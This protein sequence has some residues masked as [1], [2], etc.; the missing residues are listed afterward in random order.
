MSKAIS[1]TDLLAKKYDLIK[2]EGE[3]YDNFEEPEASGTWFISGQSGMGKTSFMLEL[4]KQLAKFDRVL[5][6]SLEEGTSLTMQKAWKRH[7]VAES[8][9]RIQ[10]IQERY[11]ELLVRLRKRQ[12][13]RYIISDSWQY[14]GMTF[15]QYLKLKEEFPNKLFIWNSQMDGSKPM[16][17]T[18]IRLLYDADL[19]IWVEGFKAFSKGR[20]LGEYAAEGLTIWDEGAQRYWTK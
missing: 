15:E 17:K 16:G 13:P 12:S 11:N 18:A 9:R 19:K 10:L 5:F 1:S 6:N 7:Q 2:W 20:Y 4:A 8:G 14:A 3:W